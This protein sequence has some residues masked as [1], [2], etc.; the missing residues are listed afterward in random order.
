ME[1]PSQS[2]RSSSRHRCLRHYVSLIAVFLLF[3]LIT[4]NIFYGRKGSVVRGPMK[5]DVCDVEL[6]ALAITIT[7]LDSRFQSLGGMKHWFH[8]LERLIVNTG[9]FS[10]LQQRIA[11]MKADRRLTIYVVFNEKSDAENLGSFGRMLFTSLI[12]G[13]E[14]YLAEKI[15]FGYSTISYAVKGGVQYHPIEAHMLHTTF[16][17]DLTSQGE[18]TS[19]MIT[20]NSFCGYRYPNFI[21]MVSCLSHSL[22]LILITLFTLL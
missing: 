1:R 22:L 9:K 5:Y 8:L 7:S 3:P 21:Y 20:Y 6:P 14:L 17:V 10:D 18:T 11:D 19:F 13:K 16:I 15:V 12:T 2:S 4:F